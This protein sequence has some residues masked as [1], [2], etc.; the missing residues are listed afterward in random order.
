[1]QLNETFRVG[2]IKK[3][4]LQ[5]WLVCINISLGY[6][7]FLCFNDISTDFICEKF[8][9]CGEEK[10]IISN[11]IFMIPLIFSPI[12][13]HITDKFGRKITLMTIATCILS[14]SFILLLLAKTHS[15]VSYAIIAI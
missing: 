13:G 11:L 8:G 4:R 14:I 1:M 6:I 5:F 2:S 15:N 3:F 9:F 7:G 12:F 10:N